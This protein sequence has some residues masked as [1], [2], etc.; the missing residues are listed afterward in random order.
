MSGTN[1]ARYD[2]PGPNQM[3]GQE[4]ME[5]AYPPAQE[6]KKNPIIEKLES[7]A[8]RNWLRRRHY[9]N[10]LMLLVFVIMLSLVTVGFGYTVLGALLFTV[11]WCVGGWFDGN[12]TVYRLLQRFL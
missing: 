8:F 9:T 6:Q 5:R 3:P 11:A 2:A 1:W 12:P 7:P 10:R 4:S